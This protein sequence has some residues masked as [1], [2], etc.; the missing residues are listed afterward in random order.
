MS[1]EVD[2][3]KLTIDVDKIRT[4]RRLC[5]FAHYHQD[6]IL[7]PH[8]LHY[9]RAIKAAGFTIVVLS[10]AK[11]GAQEQYTLYSMGIDLVLREN[12]GMDFGGW[13]EACQ[14]FFPIE[15]Q[16]LLLANDSV[17][18][19]LGKLTDFLDQ[20]LSHDADFYGAVE[21]LEI[22]PHLQSWFVLLRPAAYRSRAFAEL[23]CSPMQEMADKLALVKRYEVGLTRR[24][25]DAG[26]RYHAAFPPS[27]WSR[28]A[29]MH[30]YNPAH[31]LWREMIAAG[32]PFL[33]VELLRLN[34][35]R[36][37]DTSDWREA[38]GA[39]APELV[40]LIEEDLARRGA[41]PLPCFGTMSAWPAIYWPELRGLILSD[42]R[43][44]AKKGGM[45]GIVYLV[46]ARAILSAVRIPRR[47]HARLLTH[48]RRRTHRN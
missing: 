17:Y 41:E 26:L 10:T 11:L 18:G 16:L 37:T 36:V 5:F 9:L 44:S 35:M 46:A 19:P 40:P 1:M 8:A 12:T 48:D 27:G 45:I 4:A 22:Q 30:P 47:L 2:C 20:L 21:S 28:L 31:L 43:M 24:L 38:V 13:I 23:M 15:A 39:H 29:R 32:V 14:R 42:Y 34:R 6:G 3:S 33:K 7:A 25:V